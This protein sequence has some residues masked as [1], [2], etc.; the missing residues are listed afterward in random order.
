MTVRAPEPAPLAERKPPPLGGFNLTFLA[1]EVRRLLR[2]R[3]TVMVTVIVPV[4]LF[5]LFKQT[6]RRALAIGS[7]EFTAATTMIGIAVYGAMLAATSG[8]AMVSLERAQ[9]W[10]RQLRLTPLRPAAYIAIKI[11]VAMLLGLTSVAIVYVAGAIDGVQMAPTTWVLT[12]ILAWL[13]SFVFASYG[14]FMG[15][16]LPSENV[17][18]VIGPTL[19][20]FSLLG[21]LF[22]PISLLPSL[23]QDVAPFMP[24][25]GVASIARYPLVGGAFDPTWLLSVVVWT[26]LFAV[27][28]MLLFRRD[29]HRS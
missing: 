22:I 10:S 19:G 25:Y 12:A 2:N 26:A 28:A 29:T 1:I 21:G 5:L 23:M 9:G 4:V 6:G 18:Q 16:L 11:L 14:L 20:V 27:A 7:I 17:M 13:A 8:G 24:T 3:R 15:Y